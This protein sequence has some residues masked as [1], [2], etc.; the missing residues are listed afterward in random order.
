MA[1]RQATRRPA[2]GKRRKM[3]RR[4]MYKPKG[5]FLSLAR[6][7][8]ANYSTGT[9]GTNN[10]TANSFNLTSLPNY[11]ELTNLF[12][13]FQIK[14]IL[15]RFRVYKSP[16][17]VAPNLYPVIY[18]AIDTDD[19]LAP[20]SET[21]LMEYPGCKISVLT[22]SKP[23]TKWFPFTPKLS[24]PI[25]GAGSATGAFAPR[26]GWVSTAQP[27]AQHWGMKSAV[28]QAVTGINVAIDVKFVVWCK[29]VK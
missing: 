5:Q 26:T 4:K 23:L 12:D 3:Y 22:D 24:A 15:Y 9:T 14:K 16:D 13:F 27:A 20:T 25:Y 10:Y 21:Q 11:T 29:T 7:Y 2:G 17:V 1:K 28:T 19:S 6:M 8:T 18:H